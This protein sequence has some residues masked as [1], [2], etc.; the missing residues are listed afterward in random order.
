MEA[1]A[2]HLCCEEPAVI[3]WIKSVISS[4]RTR[5]DLVHPQKFADFRVIR[6]YRTVSDKATLLLA[7][8]PPV[9]LLGLERLR[10]RVR[11]VTGNIPGTPLPSKNQVK[12]EVRK[13]HPRRRGRDS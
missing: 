3:L 2:Y 4:A 5:A 10:I 6:A 1:Q 12:T 9:D 8:I 13:I 11:L 7:F